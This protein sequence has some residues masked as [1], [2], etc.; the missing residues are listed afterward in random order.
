MLHLSIFVLNGNEHKTR[1]KKKKK[2]NKKD[3]NKLIGKKN[4]L[5]NRSGAE[6]WLAEKG[7]ME[8][9]RQKEGRAEK[10][11]LGQSGR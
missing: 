2:L 6:S 8:D 4:N 10:G 7:G 1:T 9:L 11:R 5:R 3:K